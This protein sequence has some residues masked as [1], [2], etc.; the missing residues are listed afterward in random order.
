MSMFLD[1]VTI[2]VKA[3]KGGDGMVAFRREK[4]VPDGGPAG[5]DGGQGGD[6]VLMVD[7]GLRTLMDFRF[8][9]HFKADPGENGMSKGMHGR[10]SED[11]YIKV[12]QGTTVRDAETG[13]LLGDLIEQGQTLVIAKGGRG[14]RGNTRFASP[15][16]PAP[17]LAENGEPGQERKIELELKVLA[18]VGLVGFPSVGKSTLL[19][20]ISSARP[21]IGAYHF[22]TLVPNLGMVTTSDGRSFAVAD[23]PGL[24]EGASQG[25]GL[26]TQFLRHIERTRVILH[27]VD[28]SGMEGRDPYEDYLAINRELSTHNLRLLER[29]Q[30]IVANKMDMPD[31]EE[32]LALFKEQLAKEQTDE[33][34]EGPMIFPISGVTRKGIDSLLNATADLIEVTPEFLLYDEEIE[35]DVVQYGFKSDEPVFQID[36][37]PD[38]TWVLSGDKIEKLFQMTNFD[39]DETVMRFAR[40][41]RGLGVDEA[42]RARGAKDGDIVRIGEFE[43]EFVE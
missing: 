9:R 36:R 7:E 33:F 16:N 8:N 11:T 39:H 29:P 19:S 42:L 10:G 6:V 4:Y 41:L 3:G 23:L 2:D 31:A 25:V 24:I 17:E 40:Q 34:A 21:K 38:A 35:E 37:E 13:A 15:K 12:P 5:G 1:Q 32:N 14:G 30:I 18:D 27:V 43:F 26:G 28:M 22:T 20:V